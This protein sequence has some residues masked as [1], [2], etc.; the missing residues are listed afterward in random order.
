MISIKT[1]DCGCR[2]CLAFVA[3]LGGCRGEGRTILCCSLSS[4][5]S[6]R[7]CCLPQEEEGVGL[8]IS[9]ILGCFFLLWGVWEEGRLRERRKCSISSPPFVSCF[10]L[11]RDLQKQPL[12]VLRFFLSP[13]PSSFCFILQ[14]LVVLSVSQGREQGAHICLYF[15]LTTQLCLLAQAVK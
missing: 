5:F 8:G 15:I 13:S 1:I 6:L 14:L 9:R 4:A 10:C 12:E 3:A 7:F 2:S 11:M